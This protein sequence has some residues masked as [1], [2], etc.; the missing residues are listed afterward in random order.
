[1]NRITRTVEGGTAPPSRSG[2]IGDVLG[3][4]RH[5]CAKGRASTGRKGCKQEGGQGRVE[6]PGK[7]FPSIAVSPTLLSV[8]PRTVLL[9][10]LR[11]GGRVRFVLFGILSALRGFPH[12]L[13][14]VVNHY[15]CK[16]FSV[17]PF[18]L[19]GTL[20]VVLHV[21]V[22]PPIFVLNSIFKRYDSKTFSC[23]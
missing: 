4:L 6:A 5:I 8:S 11:L 23:E 7:A 13:W 3:G 17:S 14:K 18:F 1:M 12:Q 20:A 16:C 22:F 10:A 19:S 15:F 9:S 2:W 21:C